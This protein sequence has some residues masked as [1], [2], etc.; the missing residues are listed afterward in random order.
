MMAD[1]HDRY[2]VNN[3][4]TETETEEQAPGIFDPDILES[5]GKLGIKDQDTLHTLIN[6]SLRKALNESQPRQQAAQ[7]Q[8][9]PKQAPDQSA[10]AVE[11]SAEMRQAAGNKKAVQAVKAKYQEAGLDVDQTSPITGRYYGELPEKEEQ[12]PQADPL[13][14]EYRAEILANRGKGFHKL[15]EIKEKYRRKGFNPEGVSFR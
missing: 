8:Q 12:Q 9:Q 10:L 1:F 14:T 4:E 15:A 5:L 2:Y 11:Y 7:P 3:P 6:S 13:E